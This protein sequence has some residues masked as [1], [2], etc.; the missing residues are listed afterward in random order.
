MTFYSS[1]L[2]IQNN[3]CY[4]ISTL[5]WQ[6]SDV[7]GVCTLC[8]DILSL[9]GSRPI[10]QCF[11]NDF[12]SEGLK[13]PI[14]TACWLQFCTANGSVVLKQKISLFL[15]GCCL[16]DPSVSAQWPI[17]KN[18]GAVLFH[19]V[20]TSLSTNLQ[21]IIS[22]IKIKNYLTVKTQHNIPTLVLICRHHHHM[23]RLFIYYCEYYFYPVSLNL[24]T[25][26]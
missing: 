22:I 24:Y 2:Q 1:E 7:Q 13:A 8:A 3:P 4:W 25:Q 19:T 21:F 23:I 16:Y 18:E 6:I 10:T 17:E 20:L 5:Y 12:T 14:F 9:S 11:A 26:Q 15:V